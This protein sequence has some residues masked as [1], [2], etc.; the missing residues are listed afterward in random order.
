MEWGDWSD[1]VSFNEKELKLLKCWE[2]KPLQ[3]RCDMGW[4][5]CLSEGTH[6]FN[7]CSL[8]KPSGF[9]LF[10]NNNQKKGKKLGSVVI[11]LTTTAH[12]AQ[13]GADDTF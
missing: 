11:C 8:R 7:N 4:S 6:Y 2:Q 10:R 1:T 9:G 3:Q 5:H 12:P 13:S